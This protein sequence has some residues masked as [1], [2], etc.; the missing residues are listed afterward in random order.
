MKFKYIYK[1]LIFQ[2]SEIDVKKA[3]ISNRKLNI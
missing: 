1:T 3:N 2:D